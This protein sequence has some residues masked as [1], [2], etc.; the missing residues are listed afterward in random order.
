MKAKQ[1]SMVLILLLALVAIGFGVAPACKIVVP[2]APPGPSLA[3]PLG[4]VRGTVVVV[5]SDPK[6]DNV[7]REIA[8]PGAKVFLVPYKAQSSPVASTLS[9]LSGRFLLKTEKK[10]IFLVCVEADGFDR[11]CG[12]QRVIF[13]QGSVAYGNL[14]LRA[15]LS[16][17][18]TLGYGSV[19]LQDGRVAR[20]F[21]PSLDVNS[22]ARVE[23]SVENGAKQTSY[24][25]NLGEFVMPRVPVGKAFQIKATIDNE[26]LSRQVTS[27]AKVTVGRP[28]PFTFVLRNS[29]PR[30][31]ILSATA[32]GRPVQIAAVGASLDLHAV[33]DDPDGD[34]L[35]YRWEV[36]AGTATG[37]TG[38]DVK[39]QLPTQAGRFA[40]TVIVGDN[41][42]GY[43][44][45]SV[46]VVASTAGPKFSGTVLSST[47]SPIGG[48]LVDVNGRLTN[49][50]SA[51][52]FSLPVPEA[53]R[54]VVTIRSPGIS[55][56]GQMGYGTASFVYKAPVVGGRWTLRS[57]QVTTVDPTKPIVLQ[58]QRRDS[59][60][61]GNGA[62]TID[63]KPYLGP[64]LLQWQDGRGNPRALPDLAA[65][66]P[67][68]AK[69]V[70]QMLA[71]TSFGAFDVAKTAMATRFSPD[72]ARLPCGPGIKVEIPPNS[73]EDP[74]THVAP[75]GQVQVALSAISL[76]APDQM[77]GDYSATEKDGK[78]AGMESFGAGSIEIGHGTSRYNLKPGKT[79]T[80]TIPVDATQLVGGASL[81]ASV[82]FLYYDE[83]SG[84]WQRDGDARL[85]GSGASAAYVKEVSHFSSM[86]ADILKSGQ[87]CVAVEVAADLPLPFDVEVVMQ[88]SVVNPNV[89]QV[90]TLHVDSTTS[91]VI[92]N[93]PNNRDI[94]L[95]P[96]ISGTLPNGSTANVPAG[97]FVVN[98]GG[99]Q[100]SAVTPP[101]PNADG[102]YFSATGPC[103][104]RVTL[105]NLGPVSIGGG[106]EYLQGLSLQATNIDEFSTAVAAAIDAGAQ[107]YYE[108]ADPRGLRN[109]LTLFKDKNRFGQP[110][111][112]GEVEQDAQ[113]A[114]SGDLGFGRD[115]HCR[116]NVADDG[117]FD[118]AC[119]VTNYGQ[120]PANNP[121]Q[122][123]ANDTL[124]VTKIP[125]ATVAMEFSRVENPPGDATL[126]PD[127]ARAVKFYVYNTN[128]PAGAPLRKAD[129][130]G[131]GNRPVPQLCMICHGGTSASVA[132]D[133][134]NPTGPKA[135]AFANRND[136]MSMGANFLPF[137]L[138][139]FTFPTAK[140]RASQ[141]AAFKTL[142]TEIVR[143]VAAGTGTGADIAQ[144]IDESFYPLA[145][146]TQHNDVIAGWD[147]SN[148]TSNAHRFYQNAFSPACRTCHTAH[149]FVAP[150]YPTLTT[151]E[152]DIASVQNRVCSQKVMP[153][154][155][156]TNNV[157]W[158]SLNPNMAALL[159]LYGQTLTGWN[160]APAFQCGQS[161]QGAAVIPS[162]FSQQIY[163][164]LAYASVAGANPCINC[165]NSAGLANFA[166]TDV[167]GTYTSLL[168]AISKPS[169]GSV[170][171][172]VPSSLGSS[173]LYTRINGGGMPQGGPD[174]RS[175]DGDTPPDG[176]FDADEVAAWINAGATGP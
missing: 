72:K 101:P 81:P 71:R 134:S 163:P 84:I 130:D 140:P 70:L 78:V 35:S 18:E 69:N 82:P 64:G 137:D 37:T 43:V 87:S 109:S 120:P 119:Y 68:A 24:V 171:Y 174:L 40:A 28:E 115:M 169:S 138:Q 48:A 144:V 52:W 16:K 29:A 102:T 25:N 114:N 139:L 86:N 126:F 31:R 76:A 9:D 38:P 99:P 100:S 106:L 123:D 8:L 164:I 107:D 136:I 143:G 62:S 105:T 85:S 14:A 17:T 80:V 142:N 91:N 155:Q 94:V 170:H 154:A 113:Y 122:A 97:I 149:P 133:P 53:D 167:A 168:T 150:N 32:G 151:F 66:E 23:M 121:D 27:A 19:R 160:T 21:A 116:R 110:L 2:P 59:D 39:W 148:A 63:W 96:I 103:A 47:G 88:P 46:A 41:R 146:A 131:H 50:S 60:C 73:L 57:A 145:S 152:N 124:D 75:S 4:F 135:G 77:P 61:M 74:S 20:G 22:Y 33:A 166:V 175:F 125:D 12:E 67:A 157:F 11:T 132:A 112:A 3:G 92:Y 111:A 83:Q 10:D 55:S 56:P 129:L 128:D 6:G 13:D 176:T 65:R 7:R 89:I 1:T 30:A 118:Y 165:H 153:H 36:S 58:H 117:A 108:Q 104:A 49:A 51:G 90:R 34:K 54:Y 158:M 45:E 127:N 172:V 26:T 95:T 156:R 141:E 42:G 5:F 98:T 159:E 44:R 162:V 79:A 15:P 147:P 173:L 161:Y 93:L